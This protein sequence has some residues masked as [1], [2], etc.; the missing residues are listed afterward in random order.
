[1]NTGKNSN[2]S[3]L[4]K[5]FCDMAEN[6]VWMETTLFFFV[7]NNLRDRSFVSGLGLTF[8]SV[9]MTGVAVGAGGSGVKSMYVSGATLITTFPF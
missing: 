2:V 8:I 3:E 6:C 1:M 5:G 9:A 7:M 4:K